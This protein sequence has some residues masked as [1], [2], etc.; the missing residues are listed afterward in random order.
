ML[1][2]ASVVL[3]VESNAGTVAAVLIGAGVDD[4]GAVGLPVAFPTLA[5]VL[6]DPVDADS[7][8]RAVDP[9]ALVDV[10]V[11]SLA[12]EA[13]RALAHKLALRVG[14]ENASSVVLAGLRHAGV[15]LA[16][17]VLAYV[18]PGAVADVSL[19]LVDA[20]A[21]VLA[22]LRGA[23]VYV[24]LAVFTWKIMMMLVDGVTWL[25]SSSV[26]SVVFTDNTVIFRK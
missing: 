5:L 6:P 18:V 23:L 4:E 15:V 14:S 9:D 26:L 8:L 24:Y 22:R 10:D 1:A 20:D 2:L 25:V 17:A 3:V 7:S 11:A 21:A 19:R 16:L 13:V 12:L